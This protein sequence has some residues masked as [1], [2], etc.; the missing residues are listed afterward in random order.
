MELELCYE[1]WQTNR[2]VACCQVDRVQIGLPAASVNTSL[3][4]SESNG[5]ESCHVTLSK[6]VSHVPLGQIES[7]ESA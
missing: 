1:N 4:H 7:R 2:S 5:R 3:N 6:R